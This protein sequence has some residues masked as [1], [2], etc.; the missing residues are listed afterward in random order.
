VTGNDAAG[1][2]L[3]GA[4]DIALADRM[5]EGR[6]RILTELRKVIVGQDDVVVRRTTFSSSSSGRCRSW[7]SNMKRSSCASGS[8]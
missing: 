6:E 2:A 3:E 5:R 1:A 7:I 4:D 8:G